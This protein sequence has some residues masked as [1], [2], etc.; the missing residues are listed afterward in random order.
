MSLA[1][2]LR[3]TNNLRMTNCCHPEGAKRLKDLLIELEVIIQGCIIRVAN[4][5]NY[6]GFL[7]V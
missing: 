4:H 5:L 7:R 1:I 2:A 3:I 6:P